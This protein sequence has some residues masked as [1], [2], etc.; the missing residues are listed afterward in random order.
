MT[1]QQR[2]QRERGER[3]TAYFA[4]LDQRIPELM[5]TGHPGRRAREQADREWAEGQ[6]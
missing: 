1:D 6:K 3:R 4:F 2:K 5:A